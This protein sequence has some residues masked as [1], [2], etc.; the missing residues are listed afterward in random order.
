MT[1]VELLVVLVVLG[2]VVG[3]S[4]M[5]GGGVR[6]GHRP[7]A[8]PSARIRAARAKA[9]RTGLSVSVAIDSGHVVLLLPDGRAIGAD[10]DPLTGEPRDAAR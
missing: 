3:L 10:V 2:I 1:L 4:A 7:D 5:A 9:I 8:E 6:A